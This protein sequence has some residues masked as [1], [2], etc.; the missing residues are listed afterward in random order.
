MDDTKS[1]VLLSG[2]MILGDEFEP[3]EGYLCIKDGF[4]KEIES[5]NVESDV[6]GI[7]CPLL[8]NAHTHLGDSVFK[9]PPFVPLH[10][11]VGPGGL[12]HQIL[13]RTSRQDL[14]EG[15]RRS[16]LDMKATGTCAFAD[17]REGGPVGVEMLQEALEGIPLI[18]RILG[19]PDSGSVQVHHDCWGLGISSTRDYSSQWIEEAV[20]SARSS[21]KKIA[22]HAGESGTDDIQDALRLEPDFLVHLSQ[23][24]TEDL[25]E[26]ADAGIP[27]VICPRSN[28][29]TGVGLPDVA[30]MLEIGITV[31]MGT[32]N[33]MLNSPNIFS[34][35][36]LISKTL[37]HNDRQVFKMCTLNN[38]QI[39]GIDERVGSIC[40]GK[41]SRIMV[42]DK[43]SNNMW[44]L[45][46]PL[47]GVVRRARPSDLL[48][49]F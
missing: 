26:V 37:V 3:F 23:A 20:E 2:T 16:L 30:T 46:D 7:I 17:F 32:D 49:V 21:G 39:L 48:A 6:E 47:A 18:S 42:I 29:V 19:R 8:V 13:A 34:E 25:K 15:M 28:L 24:S 41:E 4:I 35:M 40:V 27:V 5:E 22:L 11:L 36:K 45:R 31:G 9:D 33:V 1:E 10:E 38:A 14:I 12:K 43:W 44:G